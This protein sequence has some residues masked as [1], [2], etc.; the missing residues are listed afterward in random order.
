MTPH[1]LHALAAAWSLHEARERLTELARAEAHRNTTSLLDA[2]PIRSSSAFGIRHGVGG[3]GD[4]TTAVLLAPRPTRETT[5]L[6]LLHRLDHKVTWLADQIGCAPAAVTDPTARIAAGLPYLRLQPG[7]A[8]VVAQHLAD[9]DTWV[10]DAIRRPR[11]VQPLPGIACPGCDQRT[12][13]V[14]LAGP[15][16]AWTVVCTT[17]CRCRGVAL[18]PARSCPCG[19]PS[20]VEGVAHIWPRHVVLGAVAGAAPTSTPVIVGE[21]GP[22]LIHLPNREDRP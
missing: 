5:W 11:P 10:R 15:R 12:L 8:R 7:T 18:D 14:Q 6:D 13:Y 20:A 3:H 17:G 4:P 19:M 22:E 21:P 1:H 9:E 2:A 16:D